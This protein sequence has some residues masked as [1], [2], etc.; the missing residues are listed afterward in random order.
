MCRLVRSAARELGARG[1]TVTVTLAFYKGRG[2]GR[3]ERLQDLAIRTFTRSPYSHVE[4]AAGSFKAGDIAR[5][6]SSS[7]R[8]G[9]VR[10]KEICLDGNHWDLVVLQVPADQPVALVRDNLGAG[11]DCFGVLFSQ[12]LPI[13]RHRSRRWFCSEICAAALGFARPHTYS[14]GLL[15]QHVTKMQNPTIGKE[16]A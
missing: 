4:L 9:G 13:T 11:Y 6:Y 8:D 15:F 10:S 12:I 3:L 1:S 5:C 14:P 16:V 7:M 2:Q